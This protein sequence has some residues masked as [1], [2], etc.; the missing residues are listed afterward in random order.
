MPDERLPHRTLK[1]SFWL[2]A[3]FALVFS[4]RGQTAIAMGLAVGAG[5]ACFAL[6]TLIYVIPRIFAQGN[7]AAKAGMAVAAVLK[8]P[9][10]ALVIYFALSSQLVNPVAIVA[11]VA[12]VPA[13][14]VLKVLGYQML[15]NDSRSPGED[16][17]RSKVNASN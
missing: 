2:A 13:V 9:I 7:P 12:L 3:L 15:T 5:L 6:A 17:C 14:L 11:G 10:Y 4:A 1:T 8:L 16:S